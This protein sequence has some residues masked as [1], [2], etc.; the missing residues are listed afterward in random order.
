MFGGTGLFESAPDDP[1]SQTSYV[2][3]GNE[4]LLGNGVFHF[5]NIGSGRGSTYR[6]EY[7]INKLP[8][9]TTGKVASAKGGVLQGSNKDGTLVD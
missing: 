4:P 6:L 1:V 3:T 5:V 7:D 8:G 9:S 2:A